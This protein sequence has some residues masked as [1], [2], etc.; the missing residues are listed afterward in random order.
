MRNKGSEYHEGVSLTLV[1]ESTMNLKIKVF[2][3]TLILSLAG[4]HQFGHAS[5]EEI[6][7]EDIANTVDSTGG[8][9]DLGGDKG[10]F[11]K[12]GFWQCGGKYTW[13]VAPTMKKNK[14]SLNGELEIQ[15]S[16]KWEKNSGNVQKGH[17]TVAYTQGSWNAFIAQH[18]KE[19][20]CP[21][22]RGG[23]HNGVGASVGPKGLALRIYRAGKPTHVWRADARC[24]KKQYGT[25][26][27]SLTGY[28]HNNELGSSLNQCIGS[29]PK[30]KGQYPGYI[31]NISKGF[32]LQEDISY[33]V[34]VKLKFIGKLS[35][36]AFVSG[37]TGSDWVTMTAEL[38][39]QNKKGTFSRLQK[40]SINFKIS[41]VYRDDKDLYATFGS[42]Y[43]SL[44]KAQ[45]WGSDYFIKAMQDIINGKGG[46]GGLGGSGLGGFGEGGAGFPGGAGGTQEKEIQNF[47]NQ[48]D[49]Q[50]KQPGL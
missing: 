31:A 22:L 42:N 7:I 40:G 37:L 10:Y 24:G 33:W 43:P 9:E 1:R 6:T 35:D 3:V 41:D 27:L 19:G 28:Y 45:F 17:Y 30:S 25:T 50:P 39:R 11:G 12:L 44:R 15:A 14:K 20:K 26:N 8:F 2:W 23:N 47:E 36:N 32:K 21:S 5:S 4:G 49:K 13:H 48:G 18:A 29:G 34:Q 16:F 38:I 46:V